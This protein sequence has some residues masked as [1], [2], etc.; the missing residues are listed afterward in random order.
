MY[1][2][3]TAQTAGHFIHTLFFKIHIL[4]SCGMH[5]DMLIILSLWV[6]FDRVNETD[7]PGDKSAVHPKLLAIAMR[8]TN[9]ER[10]RTVL[11]ALRMYLC[12]CKCVCVRAAAEMSCKY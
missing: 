5:T 7:H 6:V 10:W 12:V 11:S 2:T 8:E 1:Q 3:H 4:Y 9:G